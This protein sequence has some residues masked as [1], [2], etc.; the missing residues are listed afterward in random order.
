MKKFFLIISTLF[1]VGYFPKAP[2][3]AGT[4]IAAAVYYLL[5]EKWF[6]KFENS[7][8]FLV[9]ILILSI[10]SVFITSKAE[11]ILGKDDKKIVL[12]EFLGF[13]IAVLFLPKTLFIIIS[14]FILFRIFDILKPEPVNVL[15]RLPKGWGVMSDDI[16]A[17]IYANVTLQ[18]ILFFI[19][20]YSAKII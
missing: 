19:L 9:I 16:M 4:I 13:F 15:Q 8:I 17:A 6:V 2:G 7:I 3:T 14:A 20:K 10:I 1:G 18:I 5:P 11:E 12:D